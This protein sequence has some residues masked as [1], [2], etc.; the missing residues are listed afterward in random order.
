MRLVAR[1]REAVA[2]ITIVGAYAFEVTAR[3]VPGLP[4]STIRGDRCAGVDVISKSG[5]FGAPTLWRTVLR[6]NQLILRGTTHD[7]SP[8]C[9]H[10]GTIPPGLARRSSSRLA[11]KLWSRIE[12]SD[13]RLLII[14]SGA[15]LKNAATQ[16][17]ASSTPPKCAQPTRHGRTCAFSRPMT[18]ASWSN[19]ACCRPM[20]GASP[21]RTRSNGLLNGR[22]LTSCSYIAAFEVAPNGSIA[23]AGAVGIWH[24]PRVQPGWQQLHGS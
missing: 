2:D 12:A 5:T 22:Q 1:P 8:S 15:A 7:P 17:D 13:L 14:G 24:H 4:R 6:D 21:S 3:L 10:Y 19:R 16:L 23:I 18:R 20:A 11:R 9:H